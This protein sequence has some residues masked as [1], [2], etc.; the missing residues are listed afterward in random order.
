VKVR[1]HLAQYETENK[2]KGMQEFEW[3]STKSR[4]DLQQERKFKAI[5]EAKR[6]REEEQKAYRN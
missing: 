3:N 6:R 5:Q 2:Y 1:A 4:Q